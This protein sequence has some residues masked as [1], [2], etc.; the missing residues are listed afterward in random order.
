MAAARSWALGSITSSRISRWVRLAPSARRWISS[1]RRFASSAAT[2]L[3]FHRE[4]RA[5]CTLVLKRVD[6]PVDYGIVLLDSESRVSRF[7]EKPGWE[8]LYSDLANT[9]VYIMEPEALA[10]VPED[11]FSDFAQDLFPELLQSGAPVY[12][13]VT[14]GYWCDIGDLAQ[15]LQ[16][17]R[18]ILDGRVDVRLGAKRQGEAY[19]E[20]GAFVDASARLTG[21]CYIGG[22]AY[23]GERAEVGPY[24]VVCGGARME[25]D[26]G[27]KRGVLWENASLGPGAGVRGAVICDGAA[28]KAG[29]SAYEE[30]VVGKDSVIGEGGVVKPKVCIWPNKR[31]EARAVVSEDCVW[32]G[33]SKERLFEAGAVCGSIGLELSPPMAAKLGSAFALAAGGGSIGVGS[34]G[35]SA[36]VAVKQALIAGL[37][38]YGADVYDLERVSLPMLR[39]GVEALALSG[40]AM[41]SESGELAV[42]FLEAGGVPLSAKAQRDIQT[43]FRRLDEKPQAAPFLGVICMRRDIA[44]FY[45]ARLTHICDRAKMAAKPK[46]VLLSADPMT[47][48]LL[49]EIFSGC[50]WSALATNTADAAFHLETVKR[51]DA[52]FLIGDDLTVCDEAG[53]AISGQ[54]KNALLALA[55][56]IRG[57]KALA[58][59]PDTPHSLVNFLA[60]RGVYV[61][62]SKSEG[63][64]LYKDMAAISPDLALAW[65]DPA[66]GA[67]AVAQCMA[68]TG[69]SVKALFAQLPKA[70]L[71]SGFVECS[72]RDVGRVLRRMAAIR[73]PECSEGVRVRHEE[74][75]ALIRPNSGTPGL[76]V[77]AEGFS[78]EYA[79]SL[80]E[81]YIKRVEALKKEDS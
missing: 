32:G 51:A 29:A 38:A 54:S 69:L 57:A 23:V 43:A 46:R 34:D 10:R 71:R 5:L 3:N 72:W 7:Y 17:H 8:E 81:F 49:T 40:G 64:A 56:S 70:H 12:G 33:C 18:D 15:Y 24:G 14:D 4:K 31:I 9:G 19:I 80:A 44:P 68:L 55:E 2:A 6:V 67:L 37:L 77:L 36:S 50:G 11:A 45:R 25:R 75:W 63:A 27:I 47:Q 52:G 59:P 76:N 73:D 48:G 1:M 41:V 13:C 28:L 39:F 21:P 42:R 30:A 61:K 53:N 60:A 74:G 35:K 65:F 62:L 58:L 16:A 20:Q 26:A 79:E 22:G 78:E 66:A